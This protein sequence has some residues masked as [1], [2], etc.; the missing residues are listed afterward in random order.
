M[1]IKDVVFHL[2]T[3]ETAES[4]GGFAVSLA[5]ETGAHLT[6]AGLA[7]Q[8]LP[9][10]GETDPV[11]YEALAELTDERRKAAEQSYQ[12]LVASVP[13]GV[14]TELVMI[15]ALSGIARDEF[16]RLA[17]HFDLSVVGQGS[18]EAGSEDR[19]MVSGALYGSGAPVFIV[20]TTHK[21]PAKLDKAMVCW[22]GGASAA[23]ALAGAL[24][25]LARA[26]EVEVVS[27]SHKGEPD[28]ELPGFNITR[29]LARHG[30][31]ATLRKLPPADDVGVALLSHAARSGAD[32]MVMG[33]YGHWR[34]REFVFGGTTRTILSSM[35]VP[36][37]MAH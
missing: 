5:A 9:P 35:T 22:D 2:D 15:E 6:A 12:R 20:P 36:V 8:Y 37:L 4:V 13:A 29:H 19:L 7:L 1:A 26:S 21:G 10:G 11:V 30:V 23:R 18:P 25:L 32:Y 27:V 24:P 16:G 31:A 34:I 28:A 17:R 3:G 33:G 14:Q